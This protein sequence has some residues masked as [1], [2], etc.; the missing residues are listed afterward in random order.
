MG[1][2]TRGKSLQLPYILMRQIFVVKPPVI[3]RRGL[4]FRVV[5]YG[6]LDCIQFAA[7]TKH[8]SQVTGHC[9]TF[10]ERI[11]KIH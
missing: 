10:T 4:T 11:L 1:I 8:R 6:K 7:G 9:F 5:A 3:D 2:S